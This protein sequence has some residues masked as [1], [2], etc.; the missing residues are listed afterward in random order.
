M[1]INFTNLLK[2]YNLNIKGIVH[3]GAHYGEEIQEYVNN[4]IQTIT[5]FEPLSNNF[6]ILAERLQNVNADIEGYQVALGSKKSTATMYLSSNQGESSSILKPKEHLEHHP[7]VTFDGTEE[8]EVELLD[9]YNLRG[10]NFMNVD[11]QGY[12]LEVFKGASETLKNIDYIY[13]EVNRGELYEGN[14]LVEDLDKYL[15]E[16]KFER[17][18]T[19]WPN[20][21]YKW[22]DAFYIKNKKR[23]SV[24]VVK[25]FDDI[26]EKVKS[27]NDNHLYEKPTKLCEIFTSYGS[28]K[29]DNHNYS[30]FYDHV[31]S[32]LK[33]ENINLFE[34]G[35]S[36]HNGDIALA[37]GC[38]LLGFRDYFSK[39]E[40][41]GADIDPNSLIHDY[42]RIKTYLVDQTNPHMIEDLWYHPD[43]YEVEFDIMIEDGLHT[44][45]AN[46]IF[47]E[48][49]IHKLKNGGIYIIED[50]KNDEIP[51]FRQWMSTLVGYQ[52]L[53]LM[54]LQHPLRIHGAQVGTDDD[55]LDNRLMVLVK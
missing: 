15:A 23:E 27:Y 41:Y 1:L 35:L 7:D 31:F 9:S 30:T 19:H 33:D 20:D 3:V 17:V 14:P 49:S 10:A 22:G 54:A 44:F 52:Y 29:G 51:Q 13:C 16:Y 24:G 2:K 38:S 18:E 43:L 37:P 36:I 53:E 42:R 48:N 26:I 39:S 40:L 45:E 8:V 25:Y 12:E 6:D 28:D 50:I 4:G 46:K 5:V 55:I 11:V 21:E 47:F 34:L 32:S